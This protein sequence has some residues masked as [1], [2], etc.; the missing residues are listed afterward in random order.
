MDGFLL[1][2]TDLKQIVDSGTRDWPELEAEFP[3]IRQEGEY[4]RKVLDFAVF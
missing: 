2:A 1:V 3:I 4:L